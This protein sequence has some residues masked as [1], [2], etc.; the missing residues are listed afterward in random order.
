MNML[1]LVDNG[2]IFFGLCCLSE[3]VFYSFHG[4]IPLSLLVCSAD[5]FF[6]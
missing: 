2:L 3:Q 5:N 1:N 6:V 4:I